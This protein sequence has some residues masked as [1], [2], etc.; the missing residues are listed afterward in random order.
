MD[1]T[2]LT[3]IPV[4]QRSLSLSKEHYTSGLSLQ[5]KTITVYSPKYCILATYLCSPLE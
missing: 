5:I 3:R 2:H 4:A 1:K